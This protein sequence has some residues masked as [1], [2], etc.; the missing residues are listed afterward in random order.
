MITKDIDN[1]DL[2][3]I[4]ESGQCFR[5]QKLD[6]NGYRIIAFGNYLD[7][8]QD[9]NHFELSCTEEEFEKIWKNYFDIDTDYASLIARIDDND[10]FLKEAAEYGKG[11]RILNQ[12]IWEM[13]L[14]FIISQNN[15]IPRI[16]KGIEAVCSQYK[17][18]SEYL[19]DTDMYML[20]YPENVKKSGRDSLLGL[21]L[22]YRDE[23]IWNMCDY[24]MENPDFT[25]KLKKLSYDEAMKYLMSFK[26]IGKK[27][28]NC[29]CL[30]GLHHLDACPI[31]V[32]MKKIIDEEYN[33]TMPEW[34]TDEYAGVYQQYTFFYKRSG[35]K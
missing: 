21:S 29:I 13:V 10:K 25:D 27:V 34:M 9:G 18:Q 19:M 28:A 2:E 35:G 1:L 3:Q 26:G 17:V 12:D 31:D 30:F 7:I 23:Y 32:W 6:R 14:S 33:G 15:N 8:Y 24:Y 11:I 20:P 4:A 16:K 22:G 5:W